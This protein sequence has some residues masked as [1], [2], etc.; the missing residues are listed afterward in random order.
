MYVCVYITTTRR[1]G[2]VARV[3]ATGARNNGASVTATGRRRDHGRVAVM[4]WDKLLKNA[5]FID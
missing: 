2:D 4:A 5:H 1:R 3:A